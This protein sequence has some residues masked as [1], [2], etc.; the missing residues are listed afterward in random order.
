VLVAVCDFIF[1]FILYKGLS[2][3]LT[4]GWINVPKTF[5]IFIAVCPFK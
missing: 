1:L 3:Q 5:P 2:Y 4:V